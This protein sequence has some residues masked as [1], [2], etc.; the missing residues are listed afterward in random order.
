MVLPSAFNTVMYIGSARY[1]RRAASTTP[2]QPS[3][4]SEVALLEAWEQM[5]RQVVRARDSHAGTRVQ[6]PVALPA[7]AELSG[8]TQHPRTLKAPL[9]HANNHSQ[10]SL[11]ESWSSL[12]LFNHKHRGRISQRTEGTNNTPDMACC[13]NVGY[14]FQQH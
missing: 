10:D 4:D 7:V 13:K 9:L 8:G 12:S 2:V 14:W 5:P 3:P 6:R 1:G 11:E